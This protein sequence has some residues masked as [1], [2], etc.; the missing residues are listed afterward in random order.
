MADNIK[1]LFFETSMLKDR[2]ESIPNK[3]E[4][5]ALLAQLSNMVRHEDLKDLQKEIEDC[6][7]ISDLDTLK[8]NTQFLQKELGS[9]L[10]CD[11]FVNKLNI[12]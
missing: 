9:F 4:F 7:R 3:N 6:V 1:R 2:V 11:E 12:F 10:R 8:Q 5:D